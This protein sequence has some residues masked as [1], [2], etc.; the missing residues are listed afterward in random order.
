MRRIASQTLL[1]GAAFIITAGCANSE[2]W[3]IWKSNSAHF[4]SGEH[5]QFSMRNREGKPVQVTRDDV[6]LARQQNW[7]GKFITVRQEDILER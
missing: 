3:E 4:A 5:F 7:F 6:E 2:E 1:L